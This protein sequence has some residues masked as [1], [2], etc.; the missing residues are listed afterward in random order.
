MVRDFFDRSVRRHLRRCRKTASGSRQI[1]VSS[2][3]AKSR[4]IALIIAGGTTAT[5][6]RRDLSRHYGRHPSPSNDPASEN[7]R[8][9]KIPV[10]NRDTD[11]PPSCILIAV[12]SPRKDLIMNRKKYIV[13]AKR[14][15]SCAPAPPV[16]GTAGVSYGTRCSS[17]RQI[18]RRAFA[19][20]VGRDCRNTK[21]VDV[22]RR[23]RSQ[24][25]GSE[26]DTQI[27]TAKPLFVQFY[28]ALLDKIPGFPE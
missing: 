20:T 26:S 7:T 22:D 13:K 25:L 1:D 5:Q 2:D 12:R 4:R 19:W 3:A 24:L 9:G 28:H 27:R 15:I 16:C 8:L 14:R 6:D 10:D 18:T 17:R 21:R 23:V 11:A